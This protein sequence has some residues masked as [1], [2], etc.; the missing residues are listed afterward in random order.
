ML[1]SWFRNSAALN[2][3]HVNPAVNHVTTFQDHRLAENKIY[4]QHKQHSPEWFILMISSLP[5]DK[6]A[7]LHDI[8][9][10]LNQFLPLESANFIM[11]FLNSEVSLPCGKTVFGLDSLVSALQKATNSGPI[12]HNS[13][14]R[15]NNY[16]PS[17]AYM[18]CA[19]EIARCLYWIVQ[20]DFGLKALAG[21]H[22]LLCLLL[23]LISAKTDQNSLEFKSIIV[24]MLGQFCLRVPLAR[25]TVVDY[26]QIHKKSD[27]RL[28]AIYR[29][30]QSI[31]ICERQDFT[32]SSKWAVYE[33][34]IVEYQKSVIYFF[35]SLVCSAKTTDMPAWRH[36][37]TI[38][39]LDDIME[40]ILQLDRI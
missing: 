10:K 9:A 15:V 17:N 36:A 22:D 13:A 31:Q 40:V 20:R 25:E 2:Q 30:V 11:E 14:H 23:N 1:V 18:I 3:R 24:K 8:F 26:F 34:E 6:N 33:K 21:H 28:N 27:R 4:K 29:L 37:F 32:T 5:N 38:C 35:E 7:S 19:I 12:S 16:L 39:E